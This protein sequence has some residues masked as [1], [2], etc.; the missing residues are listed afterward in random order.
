MVRGYFFGMA[1]LKTKET[2]KDLQSRKEWKF[3]LTRRLYEQGFERQDIME[4]PEGLKR[5][6][7][8]EL[9]QALLI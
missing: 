1:Y 7:K 6:F 4:L 3:Q 5:E 8:A 9:N 2:Q